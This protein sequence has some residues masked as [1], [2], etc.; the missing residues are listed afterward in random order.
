MGLLLQE[1]VGSATA[2]SYV[3]GPGDLPLEQITPTGTVYYYHHDQLGSTRAITNSAGAAKA[4]YTYDPYG[5]VT[6]CTGARGTVPW[7]T[8]STGTSTVTYP[9][10]DSI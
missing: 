2:T 6:A 9:C 8:N 4:T 1:K 5:N 3:Y 10:T 7:S